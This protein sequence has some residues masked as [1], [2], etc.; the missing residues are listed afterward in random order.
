MQKDTLRIAEPCQAD[1]SAMTAGDRSRFC[2]ACKKHVHEL[3]KLSEAE[4]RELL[5]RPSA[6]GLCVR[7]VHDELG[8]VLFRDT[9]PR[10]VP[11]AA[12]VRAK[13]VLQTA[14]LA[15]PLSL[16]ACMGAAPRPEPLMGAPMEIPTDSDARADSAPP[17]LPVVGDA[18][19]PESPSI[20]GPDASPKLP[21]A[22]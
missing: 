21:V 2:G 11:A 12:L 19:A 9:F 16:T 3:V 22:R 8:H 14:L 18:G 13:R 5:A 15:V 6:E 4:A 1:W 7:A 20:E 10:P 17:L